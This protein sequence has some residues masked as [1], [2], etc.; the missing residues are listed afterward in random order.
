M[1]RMWKKTDKEKRWI[2]RWRGG[3][4]RRMGG[5]GSGRKMGMGIRRDR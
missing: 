5:F 2:E 3:G 1:K 4:Q